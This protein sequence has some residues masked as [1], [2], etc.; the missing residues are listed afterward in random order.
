LSNDPAPC[1]SCT[2]NLLL[3]N[4][5]P[6]L[7]A[8]LE[9]ARAKMAGPVDPETGRQLYKPEICR[10]PQYQRYEG[11]HVG[12]YLYELSS[13]YNSKKAQ[14]LQGELRKQHDIAN[15]S[16]ASSEQPG[17]PAVCMCCAR[18]ASTSMPH[19]DCCRARPGQPWPACYHTT[20]A[21]LVLHNC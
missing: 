13:D 5:G 16:Y 6:Q 4:A 18:H 7:K 9:E 15:Q 20:A 21:L 3:P 10:G 8:K 19:I 17:P 1:G 12:E 11:K 14:V 2:D